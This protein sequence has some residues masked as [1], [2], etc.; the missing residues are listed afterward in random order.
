M[1]SK[2]PTSNSRY[3]KVG[4]VGHDVPIELILAANALPAAL[5]GRVGEATPNADRYLEPTFLPASRSIAEQWLNGELDQFDAVVFS[6]SDDSAQRLYY[7]VC[8]LQRRGQCAGPQPL[9]FDIAS[10][11]RESS[12]A[13]TVGSTR[14]LAGELSV[15]EN[16]LRSAIERVAQRM[17]LV[18]AALQSTQSSRPAR[19]SFIQRRLHA[20]ARDWSAQ[21]DQT[22]KDSQDPLPASAD[23]TP[24]MM[25]GSAPGNEQLHEAAERAGANIIATLNA[26]TPYRSEIATNAGD[27]LEQIARRCHAHPW[28]SMQ[29]SPELFCA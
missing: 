28:R 14:R 3:R 7:Y 5:Y 12:L 16:Q 17:D 24:L 27:A 19:G 15:A 18:L 6:R 21:F 25:I 4:Y 22:L 8:E 26:S 23:A 20:A 2:T 29:Q 1:N 11:N 10:W 9:M 13:H